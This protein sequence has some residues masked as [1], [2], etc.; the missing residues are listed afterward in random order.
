[1]LGQLFRGFQLLHG[2]LFALSAIGFFIFW[3]RTRFW[4][5]K[6]A[7]VLAAIAFA[8]GLWVASTAPP[9]APIGKSG[10]I[11]KVLLALALPAIVYFFF[12]FYGGQRAAFKRRFERPTPCPYCKLP[13]K[14][15]QTGLGATDSMTS[16]VRR[17]CPHCGH[18]LI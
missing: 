4:L 11:A 12:V 10:E 9:D 7:H 1:M 16:G 18:P 3:V 15:L 2:V 8:V 14:T 13:V 6:Y 5:P 17:Q